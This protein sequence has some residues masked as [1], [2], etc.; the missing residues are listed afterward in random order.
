MGNLIKYELYFTDLNLLCTV[1]SCTVRKRTP[2]DEHSN[3]KYVLDYAD[4]CSA[5]ELFK[6]LTIFVFKHSALEIHVFF[7]DCFEECRIIPSRSF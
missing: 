2:N 4:C 3:K 1:C 7:R 6:Y 5:K